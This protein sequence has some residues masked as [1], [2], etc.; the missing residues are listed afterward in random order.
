VPKRNS[1]VRVGPGTENTDRMSLIDRI[2]LN[3]AIG[4]LA[5]GTIALSFFFTT[6]KA[7][8]MNR[9]LK[10]SAAQPIHS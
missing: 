9:S 10:C 7:T 1:P 6:L 4:Q 2:S 8:S 5:P 3:Q